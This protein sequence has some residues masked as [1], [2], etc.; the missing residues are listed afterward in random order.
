MKLA[1]KYK[2]ARIFRES[3]EM[4]PT[5]EEHLR[6]SHA[7]GMAFNRKAIQEVM[8]EFAQLHVEAALI[9]ASKGEKGLLSR[10]SILN[11]YPKELIK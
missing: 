9:E 7:T 4:I 10:D 11:A 2:N 8:A 6:N 5:A 3:K 1:E